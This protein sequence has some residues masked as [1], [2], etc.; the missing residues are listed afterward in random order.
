MHEVEVKLSAMHL[1]RRKRVMYYA[2][3]KLILQEICVSSFCTFMAKY[4]AFWKMT[5]DS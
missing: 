5:P 2:I 1:G 3:L 4:E